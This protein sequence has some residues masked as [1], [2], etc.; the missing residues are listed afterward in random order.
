MNGTKNIQRHTL[1]KAMSAGILAVVA[2][3]MGV[4]PATAD[5]AVLSCGA[6]IRSTVKLGF[7]STFT[8]MSGTYVNVP[9]AKV[10]VNV[11]AGQTQC[12]RIRFSGTASCPGGSGANQCFLRPNGQPN[13]F[14]DPAATVFT[15]SPTAAAHSFEW[16]V[17]VAEGSYPIQIQALT[18]ATS[19]EISG[20]TL[21]VDVT[22]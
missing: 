5:V 13:V 19:F 4:A 3:P 9:G 12:I 7:N 2:S 16:V 20:W 15:T 11:P 17:R 6:P 22:N 1:A 18:Q 10:T 21:V 14:F 8:T